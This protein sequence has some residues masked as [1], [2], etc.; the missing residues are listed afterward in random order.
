MKK[1]EWKK[2][3]KSNVVP[4][5]YVYEAARTKLEWTRQQYSNYVIKDTIGQHAD[6][7]YM[8][9]MAKEIEILE[10]LLKDQPF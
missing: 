5:S 1:K 4:D 3:L 8:A 2:K 7:D 6:K 10:T 9:Q